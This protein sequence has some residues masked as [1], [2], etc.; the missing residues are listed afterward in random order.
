MAV[1]LILETRKAKQEQW[2]SDELSESV[3][4]FCIAKLQ[5]TNSFT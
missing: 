3:L 1:S 2:L 4:M 5:R